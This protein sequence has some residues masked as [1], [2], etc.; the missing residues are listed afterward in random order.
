MYGQKGMSLVRQ[1]DQGGIVLTPV[2]DR[3]RQIRAYFLEDKAPADS[4][5]FCEVDEVPFQNSTF[6]TESL[7]QDDRVLLEAWTRLGELEDGSTRA[8]FGLP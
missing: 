6:R 3:V 7:S 8:L 2:F 1:T 5:T 4:R